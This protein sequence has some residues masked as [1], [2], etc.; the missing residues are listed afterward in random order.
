MRQDVDKTGVFID[1][2]IKVILTALARRG[3]MVRLSNS[4]EWT[5]NLCIYLGSPIIRT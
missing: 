3:K 2:R 4:E 1:R 5:D